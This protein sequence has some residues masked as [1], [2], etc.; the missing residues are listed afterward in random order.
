MLRTKI[1]FQSDKNL[2]VTLEQAKS[3]LAVIHNELDTIIESYIESATL[4]ASELTNRGLAA[5][6][7]VY[8][9]DSPLS[10][11]Q[12]IF[13]TIDGIDSVKSFTDGEDLSYEKSFDNSVI[14]LSA[15]SGVIVNYKTSGESQSGINTAILDYIL[16]RFN[17]QTDKEAR[18]QV[19]DNLFP[20]I[21]NVI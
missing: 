10:K 16:L 11:H 7:V 19:Y 18:E 3:H 9:Q 13:D 8:T 5:F 1:K 2:P 4:W 12:L 21:D 15:E 14:S 17:G 6:D 20:Y